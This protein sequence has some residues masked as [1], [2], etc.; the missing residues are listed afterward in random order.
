MIQEIKNQMPNGH[1]VEV[2]L[3]PAGH[4][5]ITIGKKCCSG[6]QLCAVIDPH[7]IIKAYNALK[8]EEG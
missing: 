2:E 1:P 4:F 5:T 8:G 3:T 7:D 6:N